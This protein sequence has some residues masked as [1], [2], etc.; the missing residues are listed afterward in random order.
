[1]KDEAMIRLALEC[2]AHAAAVLPAGQI[3]RS[4]EFREMCRSNRCGVY[5]RCYMCPPDVGEIEDLM[6][7]LEDY[8]RGLLYQTVS[9]LEDSFDVEGMA[10]AREEMTALSQ[11]LLDV[12][13]PLTGSHALHL[14]CGGCG[15]CRECGR[16]SGEACR[17]PDR[18]LA[19][20]ESYGIDVYNTARNTPLHYVNG[21]DTVTYFG[22]V[23][24]GEKNNG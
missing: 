11:R 22:M 3:V 16:V 15:L 4:A 7:R 20:L 19:S 13:P 5:G 8:D 12:L 2:G 23:L 1:M 21:P 14:S 6:H 17:H 9:P 10:R 24:Y 18:A